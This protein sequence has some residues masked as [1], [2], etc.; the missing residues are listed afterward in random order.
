M[1]R[2]LRCSLSP[3]LLGLLGLACGGAAADARGGNN[4]GA[5][6]SGDATAASEIL[7]ASWPADP[8]GWIPAAEVESIVGRLTGPPRPH[9]GDCFY[10]LPLDAETVR[11]KELAR[12][13]EETAEEL[14]RKLD[15]HYEPMKDMR[16]TDPGVILGVRVS[17]MDPGERILANSREMVAG[18]AGLPPDS[19]AAKKPPVPG[20]AS[21]WDHARSPFAIGIPGFAGR[22]GQLGVT[23][24][25]Q[26]T[27]VP[28]EKMAALAAKVRDRI[29]DRPFPAPH[30][31][32][33]AA[34]AGGAARAAG[35]DPCALLTRSEAEE[36]LGKL[37]VPPYRSDEGASFPDPAGQACTYYTAGHHV[38]VVTPEWTAG[39]Q[40][41]A[42]TR[43]VGSIAAMALPDREAEAADT[44][45]GPWDDVAA[46]G[47]TGELLFLIGDRLLRVG[48]AAS[49]TNAAGVLRLAR[50][51]LA[52]LAAAPAR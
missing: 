19:V 42:M 7:T 33:L 3:V 52:R 24:L 25:P 51:A 36:V 16:P 50:P 45:E 43:G 41:L 28:P 27:Y 10:P 13:M 5:S 35:P 15:Q 18:W 14:A 47:H 39:K 46:S 17:N 40:T 37:V 29:P 20:E 38:L 11:R 49:S 21:G 32:Y 12:K 2:N 6:A 8:C 44:L 34:I 4:A 26:V 30:D 22:T 1:T 23:V 9:E 31:P 48:Y